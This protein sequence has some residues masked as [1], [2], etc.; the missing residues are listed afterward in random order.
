M[1]ANRSIVNL[2]N[3]NRKI[4]L[5]FKFFKFYGDKVK[6]KARSENRVEES[7]KFPAKFELNR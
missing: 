1:I 7:I 6:N 5:N 2:S 4:T 3:F